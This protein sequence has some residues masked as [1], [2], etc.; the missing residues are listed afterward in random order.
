M[1]DCKIV[2]ADLA[3][4]GVRALIADLDRYLADLYPPESNH[5]L[6]PAELEE[7]TVRFVVAARQDDTPVG[8]GAVR[9]NDDFAEIK[10]MYVVPGARKAGIGRA[11]LAHLEKLAVTSGRSRIR[12]ETG[13]AQTEALALYEHA[14]YVRIDPFAPYGPDPLSVFMEKTVPPI[15]A[16]LGRA[17]SFP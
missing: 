16:S 2:A 3:A 11:L 4:P 1:T 17:A 9:L 7:P 5:G 14:G 15:E 12:L 8:C 10:R 13:I 6:S